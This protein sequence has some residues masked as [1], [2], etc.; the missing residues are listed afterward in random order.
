MMLGVWRHAIVRR[1]PLGCGKDLF[2][3]IAI[4]HYT[5]GSCTASGTLV[6]NPVVGDS[7]DAQMFGVGAGAE[8]R[9]DV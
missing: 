2:F 6:Q 4:Y 5:S 7:K 8:L 3:L 9:A 1:E